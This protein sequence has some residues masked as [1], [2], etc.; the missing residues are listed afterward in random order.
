MARYATPIEDTIGYE[1]YR[2]WVA[3]SDNNDHIP[4]PYIFYHVVLVGE[5]KYPISRSGFTHW[6]DRLQR[7]PTYNAMPYVWR[8]E[9]THAWRL[10]DVDISAK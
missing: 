4:D 7:P 5:D 1:I 3:Y 9:K 2:R 6:L 8:D 10:R